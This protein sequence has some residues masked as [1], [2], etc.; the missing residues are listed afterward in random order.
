MSE[1]ICLFDTG[2]TTPPTPDIPPTLT[3]G[4]VPDLAQYDVILVNLSGGKDSQVAL[5]V[6]MEAAVRAGVAHRVVCVHADLGEMEWAGT[7]FLARVH[8]VANGVTRFEVVRREIPDGNGTRHETLL[9]YAQRRRMWP[10]SKARWCTSDLKRGPIHR[11]YT[12]IVAEIDPVRIGRAV[13]LLNVMGMRAAESPARLKLAPY[14]H[15]AAA[16]N[17]RR[18]VDTWLPIHAM[19][20]EEVW[21]R[22]YASD[23]PYS[24]VY[25]STPGARDRQGMSRLS[26]IFCV[27]S[28]RRDLVLAARREPELADRYVRVEQEI[29]HDFRYRE[30]MSAIREEAQRQTAAAHARDLLAELDLEPVG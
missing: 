23:I 10:S 13:R 25:D 15:D 20:T 19:S 4:P 14:R 7:A 30:P 26:C 5:A 29:G 28:S 18:H 12:R 2:P 11:L 6:T 27:L 8:A 16:S 3:P 21:E 22:I 24:D 1:Q 17:G 9:Q